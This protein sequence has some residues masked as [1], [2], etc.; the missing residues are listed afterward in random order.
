MPSTERYKNG[1][2]TMPAADID[3]IMRR[4]TMQTADLDVLN[5]SMTD[6]VGQCETIEDA[7]AAFCMVFGVEQLRDARVVAGEAAFVFAVSEKFGRG[8]YSRMATALG[9]VYD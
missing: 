6:L 3:S 1:E 2:Q 8:P 9:L 4:L 7:A 5:K